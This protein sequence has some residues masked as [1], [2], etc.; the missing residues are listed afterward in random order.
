MNEFYER[1]ER[2]NDEMNEWTNEWMK[3]E[4]YSIPSYI[5]Y[6]YVH[7]NF[8][9]VCRSSIVNVFN[10]KLMNDIWSISLSFDILLKRS[11]INNWVIFS[12]FSM[13]LSQK[14]VL[15]AS[16]PLLNGVG[17]RSKWITKRI[18]LSSHVNGKI[19]EHIL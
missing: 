10:F 15:I 3:V 6:L 12:F 9:R 11:V 17:I 2:R 18:S 4:V 5:I 8:S 19:T 16:L 1:N 7:H 13:L 14:G